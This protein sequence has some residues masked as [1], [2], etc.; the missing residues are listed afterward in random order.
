MVALVGLG[1]LG[2]AMAGRLLAGTLTRAWW[3]LA[4]VAAIVSRRARRVVAAAVIVPIVLDIRRER[5]AL[6][7]IRYAG[8]HLLD[9]VAYG[10]GVWAGAWRGRTLDPLLLSFESWPPKEPGWQGKHAA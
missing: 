3:P 1:N 2:M 10:A 9:D 4:I 5:P 8:L 6:D 7:P